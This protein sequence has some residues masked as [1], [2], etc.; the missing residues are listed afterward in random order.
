MPQ[1]ESAGAVSRLPLNGTA[2]IGNVQFDAPPFQNQ[3]TT[4]FDWRTATPDYFKTMGIPLMMGREFTRAQSR[5][6][7]EM[8]QDRCVL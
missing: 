7:I 6:A 8:D 3:E 2:A 4:T 1:V 5:L